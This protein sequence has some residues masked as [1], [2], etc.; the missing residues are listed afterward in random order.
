MPSPAKL[1]SIYAKHQYT[2]GRIFLQVGAAIQKIVRKSC[3]PFQGKALIVFPAF[4]SVLSFET[5]TTC[6]SLSLTILE[7]LHARDIVCLP[8]SNSKPLQLPTRASAIFSSKCGMVCVAGSGAKLT[9][10]QERV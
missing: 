3:W 5:V 8:Q 1:F 10:I 7:S 9:S 6:A 2:S 4:A